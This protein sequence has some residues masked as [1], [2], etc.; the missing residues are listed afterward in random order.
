M[1]LSLSQSQHCRRERSQAVTTVFGAL[2]VG[3]ALGLLVCPPLMRR[4][5]WPSVFWIFAIVGLVW[6]F[7][8]PTLRPGD[9]DTESPPPPPETAEEKA[10]ERP[11]AASCKLTG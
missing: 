9:P 8:W 11:A 5:G 3:S 10:S 4:F 1:L 6:S 7:I 2:D